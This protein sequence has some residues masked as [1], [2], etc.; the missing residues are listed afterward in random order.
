MKEAEEEPRDRRRT[1]RVAHLTVPNVIA[2]E[3]PPGG[4]DDAVTLRTSARCP[5]DFPV[6]D[7]LEIGESLGAIDVERGAKVSSARFYFLTGPGALP[8]AR[9]RPTRD[10]P[11]GGVGFTP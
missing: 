11:G 6:R 9:P 1:L 5:N 7:H 3:V 8:A 2:D 4:E 10:Q